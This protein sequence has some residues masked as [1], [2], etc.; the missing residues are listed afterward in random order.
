MVKGAQKLVKLLISKE[1]ETQLRR[2]RVLELTSKGLTQ[3]EIA[4]RLKYSQQTIS[5]DIIYLRKKAREN[6][7]QHT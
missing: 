4:D 6:L 5:N 1:V 2:D 7:Q 3:Q